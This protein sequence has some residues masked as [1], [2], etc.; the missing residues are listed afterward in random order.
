MCTWAVLE[1]IDF[2]LRNHSDVFVCTMDM[3]KAFDLVRHS[4]LFRKLLKGG[5]PVIFIRL[6]ILI[7]ALQSANVRWNGAISDFFS[8]TNGVKQG[9]VLSAILYCFYCND[10]FKYLREKKSGCWVNG[11]YMGILGYSDDNLLIA[12]SRSSLQNML[13]VCEEYAADHN[14]KFSTD[15][16]P[17]KC[18]TKCLK[19]LQ[20]DRFVKPLDLCRNPLP[21]VDGAKHLGNFIENRIDGL[22]KDI[23]MK[24]AEYINKNNEIIQEFSFCHPKAIFHLNKVYNSHFSGSCLWDLFSREA[25]MLENTWNVSI[26][27]MFDLPIQTHTW[28]IEPISESSHVK[29]ILI[30]RFLTFVQALKSSPKLILTNLLKMISKDVQSVTGSNLRKILLLVNKSDVDDLVPEDSSKIQYRPEDEE[31]TWKI[32][33]VKELIEVR[34]GTLQVDNFN[35][36]EIKEVLDS[37]C[38]D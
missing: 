14:L 30:K 32:R 23:R 29:I 20:K 24:R 3:T 15:K 10:L 2:F 34:N 31:N 17:K 33:M 7:Y 21:W 13:Q 4:L 18:K 16:N 37:L 5:L 8:L 35:E 9:G 1:T 28:Y 38:V 26:R 6:L 22:K 36:D 11:H 12:P 19:F 27:L 25:V